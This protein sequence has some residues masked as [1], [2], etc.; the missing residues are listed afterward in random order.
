MGSAHPRC[1]DRGFDSPMMPAFES[2]RSHVFGRFMGGNGRCAGVWA[3]AAGGKRQL[4]R[5]A[6][7]PGVVSRASRRSSLCGL[8]RG[9]QMHSVAEDSDRCAD[10][11]PFLRG[12]Y[13]GVEKSQRALASLQN[14]QGRET[15][16]PLRTSSAAP[17]YACD[18]T[19]ETR[20]VGSQRGRTRG[21][22]GSPR[23]GEGRRKGVAPVVC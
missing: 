19:F 17:T 8:R 7:I 5:R 20:W 22:E 15:G 10:S 14:V 11:N 18:V 9:L 23:G 16:K 1:A 21:R 13:G 2:P 4:G 6:C 3:V 12:G